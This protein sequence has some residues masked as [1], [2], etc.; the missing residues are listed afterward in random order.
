[1]RH[2]DG[3]W[4]CSECG[5]HSNNNKH[6]VMRHIEAKHVSIYA[7]PCGQ[8]NQ[9]CKTKHTRS[10]HMKRVHKTEATSTFGMR[11]HF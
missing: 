4:M 1:M 11:P 8:C 5:Q 6:V 9:V 2:P 3:G 10:I 7:Y